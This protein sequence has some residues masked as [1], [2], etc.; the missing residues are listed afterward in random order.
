MPVSV[1]WVSFDCKRPPGSRNRWHNL[2]ACLLLVVPLQVLA[3][4]LLPEEVPERGI[5][6]VDEAFH[7]GAYPEKEGTRVFWQVMPGYFLYR[8]KFSFRRGDE[9]L[10]VELPE[11]EWRQDEIFGRV[12]VVSG[13]VEVS[14]P[15]QSRIQ[16]EYQGCAAQGFC[17]PPQKKVIN[18]EKNTLS[19]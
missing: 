17:Y 6:P 1:N 18:S 9:L 10:Q 15:G 19:P 7:L 12:Q 4:G 14:A 5:L 13:L 8:D 2:L 11:G 16:V 3:G